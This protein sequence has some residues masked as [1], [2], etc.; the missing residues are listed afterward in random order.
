MIDVARVWF[1]SL[2]FQLQKF[3][4]FA[5]DVT[6]LDKADRFCYEVRMTSCLWRSKVYLNM[7]NVV[8][9]YSLHVWSVF[10]V[11]GEIGFIRFI[12]IP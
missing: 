9:H 3:K 6:K 5:D 7:F 12:V 1:F 8:T 11:F 10:H 2:S 4:Y